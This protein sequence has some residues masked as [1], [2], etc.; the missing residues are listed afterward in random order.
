MHLVAY[1]KTEPARYPTDKLFDKAFVRNTGKTLSQRLIVIVVVEVVVF[2][3][4]CQGLVTRA[5][6]RSLRPVSEFI[7]V[8]RAL[9]F[10]I[11]RVALTRVQVLTL[12]SVLRPCWLSKSLK[13]SSLFLLSLLLGRSG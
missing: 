6:G 1:Q 13:L 4:G 8:I 3:V 12:V 5:R 7:L 11:H 2:A 10:I 9:L